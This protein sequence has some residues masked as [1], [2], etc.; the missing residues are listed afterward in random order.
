MSNAVKGGVEAGGVVAVVT[1]GR[2]DRALI[3]DLVLEGV[4][5]VEV[6]RVVRV[7]QGPHR[8]AYVVGVEAIEGQF[9]FP[10]GVDH[11]VDVVVVV[12]D[13][14]RQI[15]PD[16]RRAAS[17]SRL[18]MSTSAPCRRVPVLGITG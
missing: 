17:A 14:H 13:D 18:E 16:R 3:L 2:A 10:G 8:D 5:G 15:A 6:G 11:L 4:D 12:D 1:N 7:D 9:V